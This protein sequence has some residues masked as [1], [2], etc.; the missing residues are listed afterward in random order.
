[1][2]TRRRYPRQKTSTPR[3]TWPSAGS[4]SRASALLK[5]LWRATHCLCSF[6][7]WSANRDTRQQQPYRGFLYLVLCLFRV[8][9]LYFS[10]SLTDDLHRDVEARSPNRDA[11]FVFSCKWIMEERMQRELVFFDQGHD[12]ADV[13]CEGIPRHAG[14]ALEKACWLC[15]CVK[16]ERTSHG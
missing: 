1:M 12:F 4:C 15:L 11:F 9:C 3:N 16:R 2:R 14:R 5:M 8:L 7:S 13:S 6:A 10:V